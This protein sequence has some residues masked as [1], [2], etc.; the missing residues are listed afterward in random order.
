MLT[1]R[2]PSG[3]AVQYHTATYLVREISS[4]QLYT[5]KDGKWVASIQISA[6]VTVEAISASAVSAPP[7]ATVK[8]ALQ[9]IVNE[10]N[11]SPIMAWEETGLLCTLK[12]TL[13]RFNARKKAWK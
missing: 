4:W 5:E 3:V 12:M 13:A 7:V 1:V 6:G 9:L 8:S 10:L 2:Y 11:R